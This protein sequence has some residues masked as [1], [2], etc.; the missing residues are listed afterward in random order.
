MPDYLI[1]LSEKN[2]RESTFTHETD[3]D[4]YDWVEIN[5][6]IGNFEKYMSFD[7]K[8]KQMGYHF[9]RE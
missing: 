3:E 6:E 9:L 1:N 4:F 2:Q 5:N 8:P 7:M